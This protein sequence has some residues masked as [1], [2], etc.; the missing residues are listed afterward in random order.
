MRVSKKP[1][2]LVSLAAALAALSGTAALVPPAADAKP[3]DPSK[4]ERITDSRSE[5]VQPNVLM[6]VGKD[7]LG[8][9]VTTGAD[10]MVTA[11]HYSHYSHSSHASHSSHS[12]HY[13][14][15]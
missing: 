12:S 9:I 2:K 14:S 15:R 7:L 8:M 5:D 4:S 10:G 6:A 1:I 3:S 11:Q 13:S